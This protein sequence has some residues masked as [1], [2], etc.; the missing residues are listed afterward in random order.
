V[1]DAV[2]VAFARLL[3][4]PLRETLE[5]DRHHLH[6]VRANLLRLDDRLYDEIVERSRRNTIDPDSG[7]GGGPVAAGGMDSRARDAV[8]ARLPVALRDS[9]PLSGEEFPNLARGPPSGVASVRIVEDDLG[10]GSLIAFGWRHRE[11]AP[12]GVIVVP[13]RVARSVEELTTEQRSSR[14]RALNLADDG[15]SVCGIALALKQPQAAADHSE[16]VV[17]VVDDELRRVRYRPHPLRPAGRE[18]A[19]RVGPWSGPAQ[20]PGDLAVTPDERNL[21]APGHNEAAAV[22]ADAPYPRAECALYSKRDAGAV[23]EHD[24][25]LQPRALDRTGERIVESL[26]CLFDLHVGAPGSQRNADFRPVHEGGRRW[27]ED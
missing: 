4:E 25:I 16:K 27:L 15:L 22:I 21:H 18:H 14:D 1:R 17:D 8:V 11:H 12:H 10:D 6:E 13:A 7:R 19:A 20:N 5:L 23:R 3:P 26:F 2:T 24:D 9:R